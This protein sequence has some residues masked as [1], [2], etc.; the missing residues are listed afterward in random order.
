MPVPLINL[1]GISPLLVVIG[2]VGD[3][4]DLV[5]QTGTQLR[6]ALRLGSRLVGLHFGAANDAL[7]HDRLRGLLHRFQHGGFLLLSVVFVDL[8]TALELTLT[9]LA[10][11]DDHLFALVSAPHLIVKLLLLVALMFD[12]FDDHVLALLELQLLHDLLLLT[13]ETP[14]AL[15]PL[16]ASRLSEGLLGALLQTSRFESERAAFSGHSLAHGALSKCAAHRLAEGRGAKALVPCLLEALVNGSVSVVLLDSRLDTLRLKRVFKLL[17]AVRDLVFGILQLLLSNVVELLGLLELELELFAFP[18]TLAFLVLLPVLDTFLVPFLHKAG[19]AL[20]LVD[21]NTAHFLLAHGLDLDIFP[22]ESI[23]HRSLP[24]LLSTELGQVRL[25]VQLLLW[26]VQR[27]D[28]L[29]EELVLHLVI[30]LLRVGN[31]LGWLVISELASL[32]EHG[33]ISCRVN[34][35]E[36]HFELVQQSQGDASLTLHYLIDHL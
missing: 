25:H 27:I 14:S 18:V 33:D 3:F 4:D 26:L 10:V 34:L 5:E 16:L 22:V 21:L 8:A 31:F 12:K 32:G 24:V 36:A 17:D 28:P 19:I 11:L 9:E 29:L 1:L 15:L 23:G 30:L 6:V 20:Q 13:N 35:L 2:F 7:L